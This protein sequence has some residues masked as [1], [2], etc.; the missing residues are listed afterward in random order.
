MAPFLDSFK[1]FNLIVERVLETVALVLILLF[2]VF[3]L[4]QI[5][6]RNISFLPVIMWT[7]EMSRFTFQWMI[8][9]GATIGVL[10]SDH[11]IVDIFEGNGTVYKVVKTIR[12]FLILVV[13]VVFIVGGM[14]FAI[15]GARR[16]SMAA[17]LPMSYIYVSFFVAGV[18]MTIFTIQR[19]AI[20]FKEGVEVLDRE[21]DKQEIY[22]PIKEEEEGR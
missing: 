19:I 17:G 10:R 3:I 16:T 4:Y 14:D 8:M 6:S 5:L 2:N 22:I 11:F 18:F 12:E 7:E 15:S 13:T 9:I 21:Y 20:I 1:R